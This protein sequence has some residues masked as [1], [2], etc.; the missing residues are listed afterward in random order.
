MARRGRKTPLALVGAELD[1]EGLYQHMRRFLAHLEAKH[2]SP[3]TVA[4]REKYLKR[5]LLWCEER[6]LSKSREI[7]RAILERYQRYLFYYRKA[8]GEPLAIASQYLRLIPLGLW[9]KWLTRQGCLP[10]NPAAELELPKCGVHLPKAVLT[11]RE[12]E[13]VLAVPDLATPTGLRDRAILE[14]F[15][16][17]G[18]RRAELLHLHLQDL[19]G[20]RGVVLIREGKGRKDRVIPIGERAMAWVNSYRDQVRPQLVRGADDGTLFL[21]SRGT[22]FTLVRLSG[23]VTGYVNRAGGE[24]RGSCHLFRHTAATLM[25]E[26][27]ADIRFI[28]AQL[29]HAELSTTQ[30]YTRV[31]IGTLKAVHDATHPARFAE[32]GRHPP[33]PEDG[34]GGTE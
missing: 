10:S 25:L 18:M 22:A 16:S 2:Q 27:G 6:G 5:F 19:D 30:I 15:Y 20:E 31:S 26:N 8:D 32:P 29:G 23:L 4:T 1:P 11:A 7:D 14:T 21:T 33:D 3:E 9:F 24:K 28:Q 13:A 12:A 34:N 17:T